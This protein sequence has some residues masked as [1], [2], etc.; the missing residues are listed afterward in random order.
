MMETDLKVICLN[1]THKKEVKLIDKKTITIL[2][3]EQERLESIIH[4][5]EKSL[6]FAPEGSVLVKRYKKGA[7]FYYREDPKDRNGT[8]ILA[9]ERERAIALVQKAYDR[10]VLAAAKE[11][12]KTLNSFL[13]KFRPDALA[14]IFEKESELRQILLNPFELPD[15]QFLAEWESA[16]YEGKSFL[17]NTPLHYTD[18][19]ERVRSKSEVMIANAL[20]KEKIPYRYECPLKLGNQTIYPDFTIL[21]MR[22]RKEI[23]WE[24]LGMMDD[25]QYR[26]TALQRIHIYEANGIFPGEQLILT[27]ETYRMPLNAQVVRQMIRHYCR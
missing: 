26:D 23:Y 12:W 11:Q 27:F 15:K 17:E 16:E 22:D 25:T 8:Y 3:Q 24:H 1:E 10:K 14:N 6:S 13:T 7:Q 20:L 9:A 21:R 18:R 19:E 5:A 4:R 2:K